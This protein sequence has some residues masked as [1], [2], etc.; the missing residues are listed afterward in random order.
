MCSSSLGDPDE[1]AHRGDYAS[2]DALRRADETVGRLRA[3]DA[4]RRSS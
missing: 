4:R 2:A 3:V 1:H